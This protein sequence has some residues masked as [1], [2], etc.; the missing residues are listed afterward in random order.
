MVVVRHLDPPAVAGGK[1][2]GGLTGAAQAA[3]HGDV[4]ELIVP[5]PQDLVPELQEVVR[6]GLGAGHAPPG[7]HVP[8][9]FLRREADALIVDLIVD[10]N[11]HGHHPDAPLPGLRLGDAAFTVCYD[12]CPHCFF[13]LL[14]S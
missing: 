10:N 12:R 5:L 8:E 14:P 4:E 2:G 3:G 6:G 13:P 1:G 11:R 9:H 7:L